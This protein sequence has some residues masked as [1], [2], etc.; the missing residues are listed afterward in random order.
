[1]SYRPKGL[2]MKDYMKRLEEEESNLEYDA[3]SVRPPT[4][5]DGE[6]SALMGGD[7]LEIG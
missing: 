3:A 5:N 1:M 7:K 6:T 4:I 2:D